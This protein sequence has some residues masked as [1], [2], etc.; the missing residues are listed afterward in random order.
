MRKSVQ[1][2]IKMLSKDMENMRYG[3]IKVETLADKN[4]VS[5]LCPVCG[6]KLSKHLPNMVSVVEEQIHDIENIRFVNSEVVVECDFDHCRDEEDEDFPLE[7]PHP[8]VAVIKLAFDNT[9][10]C[11][12]F[13]YLEVRLG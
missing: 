7:V 8:L 10:M 5:I 12:Q 2:G 4:P 3:E 13:N 1:G 6:K 11:S 9:G